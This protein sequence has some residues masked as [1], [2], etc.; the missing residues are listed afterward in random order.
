M[1]LDDAAMAAAPAVESIPDT[2]ETDG[3]TEISDPRTTIVEQIKFL[4]LSQPAIP[5]HHPPS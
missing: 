4:P 5:N 2:V 1:E 3:T